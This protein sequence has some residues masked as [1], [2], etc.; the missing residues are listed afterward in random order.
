MA[1]LPR[2]AAV[3]PGTRPPAPS[4]D[5]HRQ[6]D[7][8]AAV[9]APSS[10]LHADFTRAYPG[11]ASIQ[12][13]FTLNLEA[14]S[15]TVFFGPSGC[16][17]T[18]VLRCLAGLERPDAGSIQAGEE[19]WFEAGH[20]HG[21]P[22]SRRGIGYVFQEAALFPHL[23]VSQNIGFGLRT[24]PRAERQA[25]VQDMIRIMGLEELAHRRPSELSGGQKQRVALARALA[26]RPRLVLLDEPFA[27]LDRT[28]AEHLRHNLRQILQAL[29]V[30]AVLV[31][32]DPVEALA[33]GDRLLRMAEGQIVQEGSPSEVLSRDWSGA[34][35]PMGVV[36][37]TQV[38]GRMEGL[39]KLAAGAVDLYAPDPGGSFTEAYACI[40]GEGVSLEQGAHGALTQR[41]R[42]TARIT[43]IESL[44]ALTRVH[45]EAGFPFEALITTWAHE[46]L[47]LATGQSVSALIKASA[48]RVVPIEV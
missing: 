21:V 6:E 44:G 48:V 19:T 5:N 37:R 1:D 20:G 3:D 32:H 26:P 36:V 4:L 31:T 28:A 15:L 33:L 13:A 9:P 47:A 38:V 25:R 27:S 16:G 10:R 34:D 41:N 23:D 35:E 40:R 45:L 2:E 17:K 39:L 7:A 22:A 42:F 11:G 8:P 30:P 14:F 24:W 12:A 46:D 29:N 43:G 18:T